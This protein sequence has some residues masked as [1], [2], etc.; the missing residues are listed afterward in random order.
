MRN[1]FADA[2]LDLAAADERVW[3][4]TGDLG[5][6]VLEPFAERFPG[7]FVNAGVAEQNMTGLAAGLALA[8]LR[9]FTYSI[10]NFPVVR[11]LEQ[12]RN[13]V[14]YHQL[15]VCVVAVGGGLSYA[16]LGYTH[17]G[18]EDVAVMRAL[19]GMTVIAPGDPVE[20]RLAL[21]AILARGA[22]TYLRLGKA[23]EP[24]V[25]RAPPAFEIGRGIELFSGSDVTL[26]ATGSG[27]DL[28][29]QARETLVAGG[30]S[31]GLVSL[32]TVQPLD[33]ELLR[34]LAQHSKWLVTVEE[35]RSSGLGGAVA[36]ACALHGI[37]ARLRIVACTGETQ[38]VSGTQTYLRERMGLSVQSIVELVLGLPP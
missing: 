33:L 13:D 23:G 20:T 17:H 28:A 34:K 15:P 25:H 24:L 11:C 29:R 5:F 1:A 36:E 6:S 35:H 32:H 2:L 12:I 8:G 37:A 7:R 21:P 27:L 18:L 30:R 9:P 3:L 26:V 4:V 10:A 22:P 16:Q 14:L 38:A 31:V 19:P